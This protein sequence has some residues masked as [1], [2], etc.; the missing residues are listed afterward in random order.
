M[1]V[2]MFLVGCV[3]VEVSKTP[4]EAPETQETSEPEQE[5]EPPEPE[6]QVEEPPEETPPT[7]EEPEEEAQ[8]E[9]PPE[10]EPEGPISGQAQVNISSGRF[11]PAEITVKV[12]TTVTWTNLYEAPIMISGP[13]GTFNT[14]LYGGD[15]YSYTFEKPGTYAII[16]LVEAIFFGKVYVVD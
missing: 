9:E 13:K 6:P 4:G 7:E 12:G 16:K 11:H 15:S 1:F 10:E 2:L 14:K 3:G 8:V 5:E